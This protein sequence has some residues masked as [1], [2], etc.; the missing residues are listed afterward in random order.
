[1]AIKHGIYFT[2]AQHNRL[3][4]LMQIHFRFQF[5][6]DGYPRMYFLDSC[7][8]MIRT[9]PGLQYDQHKIE[10]VDT[11]MEDHLYDTLRYHCE[12]H[13]ITPM[14]AK[15]EVRPMS[16]PLDMFSRY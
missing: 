13:L 7:P 11:S 16:D 10:D 12:Q 4:G 5:D 3:H 9:I 1:V 6:A 8:N 14:E 2:P 15:P